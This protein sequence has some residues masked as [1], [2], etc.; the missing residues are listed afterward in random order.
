LTDDGEKFTCRMPGD[1]TIVEVRLRDGTERLA[2]YACNIMDAGDFDFL[3]IDPGRDEPD[4]DSVE[5]IASDVTAWR[6]APPP[7]GDAGDWETAASRDVLAERQRQIGVEGWTPE[8]DDEHDG[9]EMAQAAACYAMGKAE[10]RSTHR[11]SSQPNPATGIHRLWPWDI[12]WWRPSDRRRNLVKAG[13]LIL[14]EIERL[15][16]ASAL[17]LARQ[18]RAKAHYD[19]VCKPIL[20]AHIAACHPAPSA[21]ASHAGEER[22]SRICNEPRSKAG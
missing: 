7:K 12:D 21:A 5:S 18:P 4:I 15:D 22:V 6:P 13:A 10:L 9:G 20:E 19:C 8:H 17:S 14:A 2:W 1:E 3:P 11:L 16:R